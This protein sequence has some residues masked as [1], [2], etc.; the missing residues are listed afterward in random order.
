MILTG[1]ANPDESRP[2]A[3]EDQPKSERWSV[4]PPALGPEAEAPRPTTPPEGAP[5][6]P[7]PPSSADGT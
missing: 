3:T 1:I 4:P 2:A 6:L 5:S 7:P